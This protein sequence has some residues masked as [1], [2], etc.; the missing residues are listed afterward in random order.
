MATETNNWQDKENRSGR[1]AAALLKNALRSRISQKF[2]RRS[3]AMDRTNVSAI[4]RQGR[5]DRLA[6]TSPKHSFIQHFGYSEPNEN[7]KATTRKPGFVKSYF[8]DGVMTGRSVRNYSRKGGF[9]SHYTRN[10]SNE[11]K[12]HISDALNSSNILENLAS[13]LGENRAVFVTSQIN[14]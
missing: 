12:D 9:V 11:N 6:I 7:V 1:K 13:E 8:R 3:G 5:L 14:F 2:K 4:F 10:I